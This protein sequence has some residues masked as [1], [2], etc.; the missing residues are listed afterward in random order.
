MA[1]SSEVQYKLPRILGG[2]VPALGAA[3]FSKKNTFSLIEV[4]VVLS[5]A[6][7]SSCSSSSSTQL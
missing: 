7:L 5:A 3:R 2:H 1:H 6:R 4:T